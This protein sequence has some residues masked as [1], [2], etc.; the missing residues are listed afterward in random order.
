MTYVCSSDHDVLW[1]TSVSTQAIARNMQV[2][3]YTL[4]YAAAGAATKMY[5]DEALAC[6][7][8]LI[9]S[10]SGIEDVHPGKAK[11]TNGCTPVDM[12]FT[13]QVG[14][15]FKGLTRKE[16]NTIILFK[17]TRILSYTEGLWYM[18]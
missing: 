2:P 12:E 13:C 17:G 10:G 11:I 6:L 18:L 15:A 8:M 1:A 9:A 4:L 5:F 14:H 7:L 16:A 3:V